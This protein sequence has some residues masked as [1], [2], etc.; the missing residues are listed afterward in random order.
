MKTPVWSPV[1]HFPDKFLC[2]LIVTASLFL[3]SE[4]NFLKGKKLDLFGKN[5][6]IR[7]LSELKK[8]SPGNIIS[9]REDYWH[10]DNIVPTTDL[11][12]RC[13]SEEASSTAATPLSP[14][15]STNGST[16]ITFYD[17]KMKFSVFYKTQSTPDYDDANNFAKNWKNAEDVAEH[18]LNLMINFAALDKV[19]TEVIVNKVSATLK[20]DEISRPLAVTTLKILNSILWKEKNTQG[21]QTVTNRLIYVKNL[22]KRPGLLCFCQDYGGAT[23]GSN[24]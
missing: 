7:E 2:G 12:L 18:L 15:T 5:D 6:K 19:E 4:T 1:H 23:W 3:L 13:G 8:C 21:L 24:L 22:L 10:F 11:H 20:C 17:I 14:P 9:W 16:P